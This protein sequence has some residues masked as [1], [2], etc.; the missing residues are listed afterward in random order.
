VEFEE[1]T[2]EILNVILVLDL[3]CGASFV[4]V[5]ESIGDD[6]ETFTDCTHECFCSLAVSWRAPILLDVRP[7]RSLDD[8]FCGVKDQACV[9]EV[10]VRTLLGECLLEDCSC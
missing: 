8:F 7:N 5:Q 1:R 6:V 4:S 3:Q 9:G 10:V 2:E